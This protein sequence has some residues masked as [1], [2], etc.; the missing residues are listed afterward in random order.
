MRTAVFIAASLDG[1][2]AGID[3]NIDW[4]LNI[5]NPDREDYG[6]KEFISNIDAIVMGRGTFQKVL[7]FPAWPYDKPVFVLSTSLNQASGNMRK[8]AVVLSLTPRETI[9]YL[10]ER[11]YSSI[12]ID[13]GKTIQSFL[14][15]DL[16]DTLIVTKVPILL[17]SGIP[18]FGN[19]QSE[20]HFKHV[21]TRVFPNG[22]VKS[23][24]ERSRA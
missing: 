9:A 2:I 19:M 7:T 16:I 6:Y 12:Y 24:Y 8:K 20:I 18:L 1:F 23:H 17:G 13:G 22:L 5:E 4:L 3:G 11:G 21:E 14:E 15:E 10:A